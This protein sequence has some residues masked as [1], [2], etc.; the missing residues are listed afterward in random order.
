[1]GPVAALPRT[2]VQVE[3]LKFHA[4]IEIWEARQW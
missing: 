2:A 1:M 3:E 4:P